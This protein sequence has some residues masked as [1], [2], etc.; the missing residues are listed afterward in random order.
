[1]ARHY[2][3]ERQAAELEQARPGEWEPLAVAVL[4]EAVAALLVV[5]PLADP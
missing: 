4:A 5:R 3:V 1:M 2:R